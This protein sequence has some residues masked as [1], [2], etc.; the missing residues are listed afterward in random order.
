M[1]TRTR[2]TRQIGRWGTG[3]RAI[4]GTAMIAGAAVIGID[5]LSA[6]LG[7]LVLPF[8]VNAVVALRGRDA[9]PVRLTGPAGQ[10]LNCAM[11]AAAFVVAPVAALLFYGASM[12]V[13]AVRGYGGCELFAV[14][15]WVWRRD[16]QIACPV[17]RPVDIAEA[18]RARR[19]ASP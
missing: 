8:A 13:A 10:C 18:H 3:A 7:L 17:F 11:I 2:T 1:L 12:L 16:D 14:S 9:L 5:A 19:T 15:N 4:V 6:L